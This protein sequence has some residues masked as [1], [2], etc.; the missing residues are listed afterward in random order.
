M[1]TGVLSDV[2]GYESSIKMMLDHIYTRHRR[3]NVRNWDTVALS[4]PLLRVLKVGETFPARWMQ[5]MLCVSLR[6]F[7]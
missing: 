2:P 6:I 7:L 3:L 5:L 4:T 1:F